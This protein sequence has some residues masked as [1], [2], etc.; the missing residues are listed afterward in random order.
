MLIKKRLFLLLLLLQLFKDL[1][2]LKLKPAT[3]L[4]GHLAGISKHDLSIKLLLLDL[5]QFLCCRSTL[6]KRSEMLR[7]CL[8]A[9]CDTVSLLAAVNVIM[10]SLLRR[11]SSLGLLLPKRSFFFVGWVNNLVVL[12]GN[13]RLPLLFLTQDLPAVHHPELL[14]GILWGLL[15]VQNGSSVVL[16]KKFS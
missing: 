7:L 6:L 16:S 9:F 12:L 10:T 13:L 11:A 8:P 2:L 14:A 1:S 3:S 4:L 5:N 15:R